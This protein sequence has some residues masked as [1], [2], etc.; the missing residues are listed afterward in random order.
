MY[1]PGRRPFS[2]EVERRE[3]HHPKQPG[4]SIRRVVKLAALAFVVGLQV[5]QASVKGS[6]AGAGGRLPSA[7][8]GEAGAAAPR[9]LPQGKD[10]PEPEAL[11]K[12]C[13]FSRHRV[14]GNP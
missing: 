4:S 7:I 11:N 3:G 5:A 6:A 13:G 14:K 2:L 10:Q 12:Y 1:G 8:R 9:T